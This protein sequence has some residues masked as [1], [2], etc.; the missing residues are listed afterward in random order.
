MVCGRTELRL[1]DLL[2]QANGTVRFQTDPL[3]VVF[4][5]R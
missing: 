3:D 2:V 4:P 5:E 1:S